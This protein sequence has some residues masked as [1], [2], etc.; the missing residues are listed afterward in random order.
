[1]K[2]M[3]GAIRK[4]FDLTGFIIAFPILVAVF[5]SMESKTWLGGMFVFVCGMVLQAAWLF[6]FGVAIVFAL[7]YEV[8]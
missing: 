2:K 5:A 4:L 8:F 3:F 7:G 6:F 1:M